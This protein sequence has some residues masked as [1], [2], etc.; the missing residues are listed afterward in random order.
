MKGLERAYADLAR[1]QRHLEEAYGARTGLDIRDFVRTIPGLDGLGRLLVH[2][3]ASRDLDLA[4]LLDRD[5]FSAWSLGT[6]AQTRTHSVVFEEASHF[7]YLAFNHHRGRDVTGL[8]MEI[9]SEVDRIFLAFGPDAPLGPEAKEQLLVELLN[10]PY[11]ASPYETARRAAASFVRSLGADP[12]SWDS[13]SFER[14]RRFFHSDLGEK[15][16]W[17]RRRAT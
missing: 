5:L 1:V 4:L 8:E 11:Q 7:V 6:G 2:T 13:E 16:H 3:D 14:L 9:Q 10:S 15:L 17:S 12:R